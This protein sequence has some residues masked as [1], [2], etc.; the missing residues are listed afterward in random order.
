MKNKNEMIRPVK[1]IRRRHMQ[2]SK[3]FIRETNAIKLNFVQ[4]FRYYD[5]VWVVGKFKGVKLEETPKEYIEWSYNNMRLSE[6]C[7]L[8]LS[9]FL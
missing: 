3:E 4:P 7:R 9:K 5:E 1:L 8:I 2:H 6:N